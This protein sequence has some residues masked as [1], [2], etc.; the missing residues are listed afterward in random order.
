MNI[1][2]STPIDGS[3]LKIK[4]QNHM[5]AKTIQETS[6]VTLSGDSFKKS[7]QNPSVH[8]A[9]NK[10]QDKKITQDQSYAAYLAA[11]GGSDPDTIWKQ[12]WDNPANTQADSTDTGHETE[13]ERWSQKYPGH[14]KRNGRYHKGSDFQTQSVYQAARQTAQDRAQAVIDYEAE[15]DKLSKAKNDEIWRK[16]HEQPKDEPIATSSSSG[17]AEPSRRLSQRTKEALERSLSK[18]KPEEDA[19]RG[20]SVSPLSTV[21]EDPRPVTPDGEWSTRRPG[22]FKL[23][24]H[25][26]D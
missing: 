9:G 12:L 10:K 22:F 14:F 11:Q 25:Y 2:S 4:K 15:R 18:R 3:F 24:G 26:Y 8:F 16:L 13:D 23:N 19:G 5:P 7:A 6:S 20:R 21:E 1:S 17:M